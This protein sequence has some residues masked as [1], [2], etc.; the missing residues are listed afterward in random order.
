MRVSKNQFVNE[1]NDDPEE[2]KG[3]NP[4]AEQFCNRESP[5]A[6]APKDCQCLARNDQ[7]HRQGN[8][9]KVAPETPGTVRNSADMNVAT[10]CRPGP[11]KGAAALEQ[12][13]TERR[14]ENDGKYGAQA[15]NNR[16]FVVENTNGLLSYF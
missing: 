14:D 6:M 4:H 7:Q 12:P 10:V 16:Y 13:A 2:P 3:E 15:A 8:K 9:E 5:L 1:A 11:K